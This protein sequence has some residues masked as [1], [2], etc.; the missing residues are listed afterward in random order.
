LWC[1]G[2]DYG[3]LLK[4]DPVYANKA[5]K[6]SELCT[7]LAAFMLKEDLEPLKASARGDR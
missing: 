4:D 3:H 7:D 5:R 2:A 1:H 6:V